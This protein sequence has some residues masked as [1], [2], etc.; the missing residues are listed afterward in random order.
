[1][2]VAAQDPLSAIEW[3]D[4]QPSEDSDYGLVPDAAAL[5]PPVKEPP[6][7][8]DAT[9]P[10]VTVAPLDAPNVDAVGL[11]PPRVTGFPQTLWHAS[12]ASQLADLIRAQNVDGQPAMQSL[13]FALLL[14]EA[15][16]PTDTRG[17]FLLARIDRLI[18][19]GAVAQSAEL[20]AL[21]NATADR[22]LFAR[23]LDLSLLAGPAVAACDVLAGR[24]RL[25]PDL[26]ARVYCLALSGHWDLALTTLE[27]G[28]ALGDVTTAQYSLLLG[29]L[30]PELAEDLPS[31][32]PSLRLTP[33]E[34]RLHEALGEPVPTHTLP[35]AFANA[36]L[37]GDSG[38]KAQIEAAE[39][40]VRAGALPEQ[41]L[42][43]FYTL[44]R[45]SASGSVWD[46]AAA[47]QRFERELAVGDTDSI[48]SALRGVW[49][50]MFDADLATPFSKSYAAAVAK[51]DLTGSAAAIKLQMILLSP[52]Y[53]TLS[54]GI[55]VNGLSHKFAVAVAQGQPEKAPAPSPRARAIAQGFAG[56]PP[57]HLR[58]LLEEKRLGEVIL[59]AM[60]LAY[61][62]HLGDDAALADA[63][64][65][66]RSIGLEDIAR[67]TAL[68]ALLLTAEG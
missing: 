12:E 68:Q 10:D 60:S 44:G 15:L 38:W 54:R 49:S 7:T 28:F 43:A 64:S 33:L 13:L 45:P 18:G 47:V 5:T 48:S 34:F 63:L 17:D 4:R 14:A 39:R 6:V 8:R 35:R 31:L 32:P 65:T 36:D 67:R 2:P 57:A 50:V 51:H 26:S 59:R 37:N 23:V 1:M 16:P 58:A 24:P 20:L 62:G 46:R 25:A 41:R 22:D 27:T 40:L 61:Q 11:L 53:E 56:K 29:F 3:L 19:M 30:D 55:E 52:E 66:F 9:R 42:F 21:T